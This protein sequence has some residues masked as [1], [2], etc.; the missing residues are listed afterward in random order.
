M[1]A[2]WRY[3]FRWL[4]RSR[5]QIRSSQFYVSVLTGLVWAWFVIAPNTFAL[6]LT[7]IGV[8]FFFALYAL[9]RLRLRLVYGRW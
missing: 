1:R 2:T 5:R 9:D 6:L 8:S 7:I 3:A 4:V